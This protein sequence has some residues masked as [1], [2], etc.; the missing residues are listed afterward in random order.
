MKR[1]IQEEVAEEVVEELKKNPDFVGIEIFGSIARREIK[2]TSDVDIQVISR[3]AKKTELVCGERKGIDYHYFIM[4]LE[5]LLKLKD[6][7][8][9]LFDT[10]HSFIVYDPEN[11]LS[12]L[13]ESKRIFRKTSKGS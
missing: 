1:T 11:I 5:A 4:P 10:E 6:N 7:Y 3:K 12:E 13:Y 2:P 8:L 9:F